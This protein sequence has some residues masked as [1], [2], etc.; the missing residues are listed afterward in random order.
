MVFLWLYLPI[1]HPTSSNARSVLATLA[2]A[3]AACTARKV[4]DLEAQTAEAEM[5][6]DD[7]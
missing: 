1:S 5:M 7:G 2:N 6:V 4:P 3:L